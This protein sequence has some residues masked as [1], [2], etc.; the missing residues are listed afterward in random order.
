MYTN[1]HTGESYDRGFD[2]LMLGFAVFLL[3]AGAAAA[4]AVIECRE[5]VE[6]LASLLLEAR[7]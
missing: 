7:L 3:C 1:R 2:A 6:G 4:F 5:A